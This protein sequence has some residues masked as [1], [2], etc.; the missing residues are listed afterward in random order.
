MFDGAKIISNP[1]PID[2]SDADQI[3]SIVYYL[4]KANNIN[5]VSPLCGID[6][7]AIE[8]EFKKDS[9]YNSQFQH[10]KIADSV[11]SL[12]NVS[13]ETI[14]YVQTSFNRVSEGVVYET[15][16]AKYLLKR[17]SYP[18][19]AEKV[20]EFNNEKLISYHTQKIDTLWIQYRNKKYVAN[21]VK[22]KNDLI[23]LK[24]K[25]QNNN[26]VQFDKYIIPLVNSDEKIELRLEKI[27]L[28]YINNFE[29]IDYYILI[30]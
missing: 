15:N 27:Q 4:V 19:N 25:K 7:I 28:N 6:L 14:N 10:Y 20:F 1:K 13:E 17:E 5:D 22:M 30:K 23:A 8:T 2:K 24:Q 26:Y 16:G 3:R 21:L 29:I 9:N 18:Y 12:L 11:L